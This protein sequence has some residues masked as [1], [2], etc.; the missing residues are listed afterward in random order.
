MKQI[1]SF[2]ARGRL[3]FPGLWGTAVVV[4]VLAAACGHQHRPDLKAGEQL[5]RSYCASCHEYPSP[6]LLDKASWR[7][8]VLPVM[9]GF[10]GLYYR[11]DSLMEKPVAL[12]AQDS[13]VRPPEVSISPADFR[14]I[15][16]YY[17]AMAPDS[18]AQDT[19]SIV[20]I[21]DLFTVVAPD[22]TVPP[23][24]TAVAIDPA[25]HLVYQADAL[26]RSV[27]VFD[28]RLRLLR[29]IPTF[30]IGT[31]FRLRGDTVFVTN[32]GE[33]QPN[34][35]HLT[36]NIMALVRPGG[37]GFY[38]P[39][40]VLDSLDRAVQSI[41]TDIDGDGRPDLVVT[42]FGFWRGAFCWY[43]NLGNGKYARHTIVDRPG[44]EVVYAA[45]A[46]HDGRP[47][48]WVLFGQA[49]EGI[50]LF[51]NEG[52]GRFR[53][54]RLLSLPPCYGSSFFELADMNG[55]GKPDLVYTAG[56]NNDF[57][58]VPKPY[59]GVYIFLNEGGDLF[60]QAFFYPI[61]GCY[62]AVAVDLNGDGRQDLACISYYA[63]YLHRP[64]ESF[65]LLENQGGLH[66]RAGTLPDL[67]SGRWQC[68]DV[69]DVDGDG[70]PDIVLGNDASP[71]GLLEQQ[72]KGWL[73]APALVL[74][75]G[76]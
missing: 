70:K 22:S 69:G 63:D 41:E 53:E 10:M 19:G 3:Y 54:R 40:I 37:A 49:R 23:L 57:S 1:R 43:R 2:P 33:Y 44:A 17:L 35:G 59:H 29:R 8:G 14:K 31:A 71:D 46:N 25:H 32:I 34:P 28:D 52:G 5:A 65:V 47:D 26:T 56:D 64:R 4:A 18:L 27:N 38:G 20:L 58:R 12:A 55:D 74:L 9:A 30:N 21:P 15:A 72:L 67:P 16:D 51:L 6:D 13:A 50:S 39:H 75:K 66:F 42:E 61:H 24:T 7:N 62:K 76:R 45:D 73:A 68:M 11:M 36:G 48:L 60:R